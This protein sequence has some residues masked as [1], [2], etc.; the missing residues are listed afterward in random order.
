MNGNTA[1]LSW[2]PTTDHLEPT[3]TPEYYILYTRIDGGGFDTGQRIDGTHTFVTQTPE[4]IYSYRITAVNSGGESFDSETLSTCYT[5]NS[6]GNILIVNGFTRTSA[7]ERISTD[8]TAGFIHS[9]D[10]GVPYIEDISFI[11]EQR[12][13]DRSLSRSDNDMNALGTSYHDCESITLAGNTFDYPALHGAAIV[14]AGYSFSSA[15]S[16][17]V[18][19]GH[20]SLDHIDAIDL[21]LGKQRT[22]TIGRNTTQRHIAISTALQNILRKYTDRGGALLISGAY[23][24]AD[25][26]THGDSDFAH[27]VLHANYGGY[28]TCAHR[29]ATPISLATKRNKRSCLIG[30]VNLNTEP[31][32]HHYMLE[33]AEIVNPAAEAHTILCYDDGSSAAIAYGGTHRVIVMGFPIEV[34]TSDAARNR[35]I[36]KSLD[37]LLSQSEHKD[38]TPQTKRKRRKN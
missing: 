15:S 5:P 32:P 26:T 3:A 24:L 31:S 36:A 19:S 16:S 35:A 34:I 2:Q 28:T 13:F 37:Y 20:I 6:K 7:P 14:R 4:H 30:E 21:I 33:S 10:G 9:Y 29:V 23:T 22:T 11:G 18:E 27:E 38:Q 25:L 8:S 1:H 17:A 12:I